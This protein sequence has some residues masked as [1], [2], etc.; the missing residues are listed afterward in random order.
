MSK[1]VRRIIPFGSGDIPAVQ[2]WLEDMAE[3]GLFFKES[4]LLFA[5]FTKGEPKKMRY[6][7]DFCDV[8]ACDIPEE[9]KELY[10]R[11][12]WQVV[13]DYN[14]DLV[15]VCTDDPDAPEIYTDPELLVKPLK[16]ISGKQLAAWLFLWLLCINVNYGNL[17]SYIEVSFSGII[18]YL[19]DFGTWYYIALRLLQLVLLFEAIFH[20]VSWLRLRKLIK[21]LKNG[22]ELPKGEH[23][24]F[25]AA[26]G[27]LLV[28]LAVPAVIL[29]GV[30]LF[31][32][33][34][35]IGLN[36]G[37]PIKDIG[38]MPFP[39]PAELGIECGGSCNNY[40]TEHSDILA[41]KVA[42]Y[43]HSND[44]YGKDAFRYEVRYYDM[45][46]QS[47][48]KALY[49]DY[50]ADVSSFDPEQYALFADDIHRSNNAGCWDG[51]YM[52]QITTKSYELDGAELTLVRDRFADSDYCINQILCIR[53]ENQVEYVLYQGSGSIEDYAQDFVDC[54]KKEV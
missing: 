12:G 16:N 45:R 2:S 27:K 3:K 19:L 49:G 17:D 52:P 10:E 35:P 4:G 48:A 36:S 51:E 37:E 47:M 32:I 31:F 5:K 50:V 34:Y 13:G 43:T 39:T 18:R 20:F 33:G 21:K 25:R 23:R 22:E 14:S 28:P 46:T 38:A 1:Y 53:L 6:R 7:L 44:H 29:W 26:V 42:E 11:S 30:H 8:V 41:S 24:S 40:G 54:L 15:V 9:K